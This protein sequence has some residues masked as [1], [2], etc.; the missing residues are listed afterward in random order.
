MEIIKLHKQLNDLPIPTK[1]SANGC[2]TNPGRHAPENKAESKATREVEE[3]K[4]KQLLPHPIIN[5]YRKLT[6]DEIV[7][8]TSSFSEEFKIGIITFGTVYKCKLHHTT[9]AVKV[10]HSKHSATN[11]QFLQELKILSSIHHPHLLLL[12][13][14]VFEESSL[15][16][17]YM[18][19]GSLDDRLF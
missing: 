10:L 3:N 2:F 12:L 5:Q 7:V 11:K 13:A 18:E 19:N 15:V 4:A 9:V 8:A 17:E 14:T 1:C 16:Y 6:W